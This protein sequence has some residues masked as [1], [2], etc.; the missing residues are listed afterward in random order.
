MS[1]SIV[2]PA[3]N[4]YLNLT[5]LIDEINKH[6]N[7]QL[8]YEILIID[9]C[10]NDDTP[11]LFKENFF[12]KLKYIRNSKNLG[13]SK[14]VLI[15]I[16]E[17]KYNT[18]ITIDADLQNNPKDILKLYNIYKASDEVKLVGGIRNKR[19]DNLTKIISS[20]IANKVRMLILNDN[21]RD[22]GCS[23]KVFDKKIFLSF[24]FFDGIHRFLPALF[25]G[26]NHK[27]AF[28]NVDHRL[29]KHGNSKYGTI[30]RLY[31]GIID[32]IKV[33]KIIKNNN[34]NNE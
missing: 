8:N 2:I 1:V 29:R 31:R 17:S 22:T 3:Y 32:I 27:A 34:M 16:K 10:S 23:L 9:D 20:K 28:V 13:Q 5:I 21:C 19:Q 12:N 33:K 25:N 6:L 24:P 11:I 4:E 15:G 18:I 7:D 26:F 30:D 14:S